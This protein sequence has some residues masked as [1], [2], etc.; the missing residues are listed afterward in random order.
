MNEY[1]LLSTVTNLENLGHDSTS[2]FDELLRRVTPAEQLKDVL[3]L[4]E[5]L[6]LLAKEDG[7]PMIMW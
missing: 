7:K 4:L 2:V 6:T 5:C 3:I 1:G